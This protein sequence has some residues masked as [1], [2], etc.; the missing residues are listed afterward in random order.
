MSSDNE[1]QEIFHRSLFNTSLFDDDKDLDT[2]QC[3]DTFSGLSLPNIDS[4]SL[5][6]VRVDVDTQAVEI[7]GNVAA[8]AI[9]H[10]ERPRAQAKSTSWTEVVIESHDEKDK[11]KERKTASN[12]ATKTSTG[13]QMDEDLSPMAGAMSVMEQELDNEDKYRP[14]STEEELEKH[15]KESTSE[16][17]SKVSS[18]SSSGVGTYNSGDKRM[19]KLVTTEEIRRNEK[20]LV[21]NMVP[22]SAPKLLSNNLNIGKILHCLANFASKT[23]L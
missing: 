15:E 22:T 23:C 21:S 18:A 9:G 6:N 20:K 1:D 3:G 5:T 2:S 17:A 13:T 14:N 12:N 8:A 10:P 19:N 4:V 16:T 11:F 7:Q